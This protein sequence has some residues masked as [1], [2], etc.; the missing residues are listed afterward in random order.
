MSAH[1]LCVSLA[2]RDAEEAMVATIGACVIAVR[3]NIQRHRWNP[4][5]PAFRFRDCRRCHRPEDP[6]WLGCAVAADRWLRAAHEPDHAA[7]EEPR[8]RA[9][10]R[11]GPKTRPLR[12]YIHASTRVP[13]SL[14][15]H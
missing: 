2:G 11:G 13:P 3:W 5:D 6:P 9:G 10:S 8:G 4:D 7:A 15:A 14:R 12:L 1:S